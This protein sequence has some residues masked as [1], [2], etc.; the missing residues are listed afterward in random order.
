AKSCQALG[1]DIF[2]ETPIQK[3]MVKDGKAV[4]VIAKG[5]R[6]YQA[7]VI[8]SAVDPNVTF[9]KLMDDQDVDAN[10]L[11]NVRRI[12]YDSASV[13]INL[14][15]SELPNFTACPGGLGPQHRGTIHI[16]PN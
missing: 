14:A 3:I 13:K 7:K 4:G 16:C 10:F 12:N 2:T 9:N 15:L 11:R 8:A 5:G 6:E 1:V